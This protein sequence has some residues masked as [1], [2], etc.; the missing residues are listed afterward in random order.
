MI[1]KILRKLLQNLFLLKFEINKNKKILRIPNNYLEK[2][3]N[4]LCALPS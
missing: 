4:P 3:K 2:S 1:K